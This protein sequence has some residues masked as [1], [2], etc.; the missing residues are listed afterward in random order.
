MISTASP[1]KPQ[2]SQSLEQNCSGAS[3]H[4]WLQRLCI[5]CAADKVASDTI[6]DKSDPNFPTDWGTESKPCG[7]PLL[8]GRTSGS[9]PPGSGA[10]ACVSEQRSALAQE[11]HQL[12]GNDT[13]AGCPAHAQCL[14]TTTMPADYGGPLCICLCAGRPCA[15]VQ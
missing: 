10:F 1:S 7:Y 4:T 13:D 11:Q 5:I 15:A 9:N 14:P 6:V 8:N 3:L 2:M 12:L